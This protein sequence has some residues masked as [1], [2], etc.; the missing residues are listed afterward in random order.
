MNFFVLFG[1]T[2]PVAEWTKPTKRNLFYRGRDEWNLQKKKNYR[3]KY[4]L[5]L[6]RNYL[7]SWKLENPW[8]PKIRGPTRGQHFFCSEII[9]MAIEGTLFF[10]CYSWRVTYISE[11]VRKAK[12]PSIMNMQH[13]HACSTNSCI[14]VLQLTQPSLC[15][16]ELP[17][18][19]WICNKLI[20][21]ISKILKTRK[22]VSR[23][24]EKN[25]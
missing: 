12:A 14:E 7:R 1:L 19:F 4:P 6:F 15:K 25:T 8:A 18:N 20:K 13:A 11:E 22:F 3:R 5:I 10:G 23:T 17:F 21:N 2:I 9:K 24:L 16:A